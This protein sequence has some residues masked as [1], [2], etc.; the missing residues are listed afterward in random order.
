[1]NHL[2]RLRTLDADARLVQRIG[3]VLAWDQETYMPPAAIEERG[4][5]IAFIE[6]LAH[7]RQTSP[8]IGEHLAVLGS[9]VE[10]PEGDPTLPPLDRAYLRVMRR[11][12][13]Q[14]T[15]IPTE[16]VAEMAKA[17]S[18]SQAA[19]AKA[20]ETNDFGAFAPHLS[21]MV[22]F[23]KRIAAC[24]EPSKPPYDV[25][26]DR[27]EE[28]ATEAGVK[29][30]FTPL[31]DDLVQLMDKIRARPQV[32]D[33]FLHAA[34][35]ADKQA[36]ASEYLLAALSF[37]RDRGR[38]DTTAH[39]FTTTLGRDDV[40]ITTRYVEDYFPSS[41]FSTIHECGHALYELGIDPAPEYRRTGL[42]DASSMAVHESQ[43][44]MWENMVGRSRG[45]WAKHLPEFQRMLAPVLDGV[46]LNAFYKAVNRVEPSLIRTEADEVTYGLHI[47]LRFELES[48][49]VA[50]RLAVAD[51]PAAWNERMQR[52]LG[53]TPPNDA[54]G[55][56]QDIHWSMG[57]IGYFPSYALGNLYAA[58]LWD[59]M[60]AQGLDP[61]A[62]VD[63]GDLASILA[64]LRDKVHK[65]GA[66]MKPEDLLRSATGSGLDPSHFVRYLNHKYGEV[67]GF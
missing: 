33:A 7:D 20:R 13:D 58:Q 11:A 15:R 27:F 29:A 50:G 31:R 4:D 14:A 65:P 46:D 61:V 48:D 6:A 1:M 36:K 30:V 66:S 62:A 53:V 56:L 12:Y 21:K 43:S 24:L 55:C 47:I 60:K 26:L 23:N 37:D 16:L 35:P 52:L 10:R 49:L 2:E 25:L 8:E 28:G 67:Y 57:A 9:T 34:C 18:L 22:E 51:V 19:W 38:M 40:R 45:F 42:A 39:P 17:T 5:Q 63:K 32:D 64:W 44:R 41:A 54:K 3:A 59:A